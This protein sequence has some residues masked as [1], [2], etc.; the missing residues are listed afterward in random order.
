MN[1]I[2]LY[3]RV[4][5]MLLACTFFM[6]FIVV[7]PANAAAPQIIIRDGMIQFEITSTAASTS[8]RYRTVGWVVTRDQVCTATLPKQCSDPRS[9]PHALFLDQEVQHTGQHP[10]PPIPGQ[11]L[12]SYYEISEDVVT[13]RLWQAGMDGIQDNDNLYF[14]AVMVSING[15]GSVRKGP[16]YTLSGIKQAEDWRV[17]DDL[18]DY[19]GLHIPYRSAN[20]PVDVIAKT[21]SGRVINQSDVT[22]HKGKYKIGETINHEFPATIED[23]GKTYSIVRSYLSPKQDVTQKNWLQEDPATNDKVRIRS[24]TVALGGTDAIA[25]YVE[26]NPVK[27]IYQKEDGTKLKEL[28]KG[29]FS[30]G[31]EANHTFEATLTNAGQT[32]EI[33][34]SYI[35][36]NNK[37]DEQNFVQEKGDTKLRERSILVGTGGSNFIGIYKI[38]SPVTVTSRIEAQ[39]SV[40]S[41]VTTVDGTFIFEAKSQ[42]PLKSYEIT[43]IENATLAVSSDKSGT[44]SG[45][46]AQ[47]SFPIKI[48][49]A[50]GSNVTVKITVVVK[51][52]SDQSGDSTA[53]HTVNK[54]GG[55]GGETMPG[56]S[57]ESAMMDAGASAVIKA[58]ARGA[59]RFDV[60]QGIPTSESLYVNA[61]AKSYLFR[62]KFTEVKG[63]KTYPITVSRTYSLRWTEYISG[64]PDADGHPTTIPISRSDSQTVTQNYTIE[65]KYNYWTIQNLEVYGIQKAAFANYALPSGTVTLE[66]NSYTPPSVTATH[67]ASINAH[68]VDPVYA[69]VTLSGQ[70]VQGGSSRP[71]VPNENWKNEAEKAIG[72]IKVKNDSLIFNGQTIMD[73]R[74]VE[75]TAPAPGTIPAPPTIGQNVL[76]GSGYLIDAAKSNK[77]NQSS[78]GTIHYSPIKG[79]GGGQN[80]SFAISGIN[81]VTV[82]TPVVNQASVSDDRAHNQ[83]TQ[84][85][86]GRSALILDRPFTITIPTNG[87]HK[88][89]KGYG[90]R[91]YAK[92][93]KDKQV[94]FPFDVYRTD[95][96]TFI[97]KDT[98]VSVP[99]SQTQIIFYL[100]V[101][102][103]EGNYD[104]LFRTIAENSPASFTS[105]PNANLDLSHHVATQVVPVEVIGRLYDFHITDIA[106]YQWET[107]F[108][109][110]TGSATPTGKAFWVGMNG[111]DG[112]PRG[113]SA[114]YV[115]PIRPGSHPDSGKKNVAVKTGYHFKFE[116]KTLGNMF[117]AGDGVRITPTF[118]F[119]DKQGKNRQQ[120]DLYYHS[121]NKRFIR[122]GSTEDTEQRLVTLDTRLRNVSQ[123]ELTNTARSQWSLNGSSGSQASY[124]QQYL[125][126]AAQKQILTGGY[127]GL[128][129]PSQL[130]TFVGSMNVPSGVNAARANAAVQKWYGE[131]SLPAAPYAVPKGFNLAEYGRKNRL[132]DK[133]PI[134]LKDGYIIVN[135]KIETIRNREIN[136]PYL[137]YIH[138]P[139]NNQW[140]MEGFKRSFVDPFGN[141]FAPMDGDVV[142]Y[143][144]D[145]S[146]YDDFG[147]G[148]TH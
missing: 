90:N 100:P 49:F 88:S 29:V 97:P 126:D 35:T 31:D 41:S 86:A 26:H 136:N 63:T 125:K 85:T 23:G 87:R 16:F 96:T 76:Y 46:S 140:Q 105:Q 75:E 71:S 78:T 129:L 134:F 27:A 93:M 40:D 119:V 73:N 25:E 55:N 44:L 9:K 48:P 32:Y 42:Q 53:V 74:T 89:I 99:V 114:P 8:I 58:D 72:K 19:F 124:V 61:T 110:Q 52:T 98:W 20:F 30:T 147:T 66:P 65:R 106:D 81:P 50:S 47:K 7:Q 82:H 112:A 17:P 59:E 118:Y 70:T 68:I 135:F 69:N 103:D 11:P 138:A 2:K 108:R 107:V 22:Y 80:Q 14:Y 115:L 128:L 122:I 1:S 13:Q 36:N 137:Q 45:R 104:V 57:Q 130:R 51:D 5:C 34:R 15:D 33:I 37:P 91:D 127:D 83:K 143:H 146:S 12:T 60:Q 121:G 38:P 79:I 113:N 10:N 101:W 142:L 77:A 39:S 54:G 67:D 43:K 84:P 3:K 95:R 145:L 117:G 139:L 64:P 28:D 148:G 24:F 21:V 92:Y 6:P 56:G 133:S 109:T 62:N 111:I 141:T 131:Y 94:R 123:Q 144:A 116:V 18:D 102:V 4:L 120:V 132:D